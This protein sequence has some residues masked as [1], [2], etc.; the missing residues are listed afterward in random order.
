[1]LEVVSV[2]SILFGILLLANALSFLAKNLPSTIVKSPK[3]G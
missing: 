3:L 1:M 2:T